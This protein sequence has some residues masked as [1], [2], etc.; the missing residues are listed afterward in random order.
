MK[1]KTLLP[2]LAVPLGISTPAYAEDELHYKLTGIGSASMSIL[3]GDDGAEFDVQARELA[4][5]AKVKTD[6]CQ[7]FF[8]GNLVGPE[9]ELPIV[10]GSWLG[11]NVGPVTLSGGRKIHSPNPDWVLP[12]GRLEV[13]DYGL[14]SFSPLKQEGLEASLQ[15]G[16][17]KLDLGAFVGGESFMGSLSSSSILPHLKISTRTLLD[18]DH[19]QGTL[20][21]QMTDNFH[22]SL[23]VSALRDAEETRAYVAAKLAHTI[24]DTVTPYARYELH[25]GETSNRWIAGVNYQP[26][27]YSTIRAEVVSEDGKVPTGGQVI[28]QFNPSVSNFDQ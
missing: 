18:S 23:L 12:S 21:I 27:G 17:H 22:P 5:A 14:P 15:L 11:C 28:F 1:L 16:A 3:E 6:H 19:L 20:A 8:F 9:N 4:L 13:S 26:N 7:G 2:L 24:N 25:Q 10:L